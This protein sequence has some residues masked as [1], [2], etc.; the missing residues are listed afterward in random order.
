M[1]T[2]VVGLGAWCDYVTEEE[3]RQY[4]TKPAPP[5]YLAKP[6]PS[7]EQPEQ[8]VEDDRNGPGWS[9]LSRL[10][11]DQIEEAIENFKRGLNF[12]VEEFATLSDGHRLLLANDRGWGGTMSG[13]R[14]PD[15]MW[16]YLTIEDIERTALNVVL[17]D[18]AEETGEEHPWTL[19]AERIRTLGVETTPDE[20]RH[21]PYDV[22]LSQRL[23]ARLTRSG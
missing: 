18:D 5:E 8:S 14:V 12:R 2:K 1:S 10:T 19:L 16:A 6:A 9:D 17:P 21:L 3:Y 7:A 4:L 11:A 13:G 22:V 15:G 20:L 23:R